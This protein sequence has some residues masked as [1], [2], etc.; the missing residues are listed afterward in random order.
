[1]RRNGRLLIVL[2]VTLAL[3]AGALAV[4]ALTGG[5]DD[6]EPPTSGDT[7]QPSEIVIVRAKRDVPAHTILKADDVEEIEVSSDQVTPDSVQSA[8]EVIGFSYSIDLVAEQ[9]LLRSNLEQ[10]GL[11]N[12]LAA[13]T[14]AI[15][16]PVDQV[17]LLGGLLRDDDRVD[18]VYTISVSLIRVLPT[19]PLEL[20]EELTLRDIATTLP[21]Y[22]ESP[23][24]TYPYPGEEGSRFLISDVPDGDPQAKLVL[25][26]LRVIRVV[27][28]DSTGTGG[29]QVSSGDGS[30]VVLEVNADQSELVTFMTNYGKIQLV[31][32]G[33]D[34]TETAT[35]N[36]TNLEQMVNENAYPYPKTVRVPGPGAQ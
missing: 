28:G 36:G 24:A 27:S 9:R 1:M 16:I 13:G 8:G 2:G 30:Y 31:L 35:T 6:E 25:Q 3:A 32:R 15:A 34:D 29:S 21:L 4:F 11:A 23:G 7:P 17:N 20:P 33:P 10:P 22:G 19:E 14:R 12:E 18:I 5:D 26:N